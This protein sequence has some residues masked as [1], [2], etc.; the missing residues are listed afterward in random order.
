MSSQPSEPSLPE[1][2]DRDDPDDMS[3]QANDNTSSTDGPSSSQS[4]KKMA[5]YRQQAL[6]DSVRFRLQAD[7]AEA[8]LLLESL[9]NHVDGWCQICEF[10]PTVGIL[11]SYC[12]GHFS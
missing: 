2:L 10:A 3:F 12:W 6:V 1:M 5:A 8:R 9:P 11:I 4:P 7:P